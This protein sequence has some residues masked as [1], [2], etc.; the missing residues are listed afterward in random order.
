MHNTDQII[1]AFSARDKA[2]TASSEKLSKQYNRLSLARIAL[3]ICAVVAL[4]YFANA[5][6]FTAV[7]GIA[8]IFPILFGIL[9]KIHN[10]I[11]YEK[12]HALFSA[13]I[14]QQELL[15]LDRNL[16][17]FDTGERFM[18]ANHPYLADLDIFGKNSLFQLL[19]RCTTESSKQ[20]LA[21]WMSQAAPADE[22]MARQRAVQELSP[23]ID[24]RQDFQAS[25]MHYEDK[26]SNVRTLLEWLSSPTQFAGKPIYRIIVFVFPV[27]AIAA[28]VGYFWGYCHYIIPLL[29]IVLNLAIMRKATP[30]AADT[31]EKTYQSIK[32]LKSYQAMIEKIEQQ[33]FES[34]KLATLKS[35]FSHDSFSASHKIH[36]LSR[37]L[38]WLNARNNAFYFLFNIILLLDIRLLLIAEK[39]KAQAQ[40]DASKWFDAISEIEA[41]TSLA[42]FAHAHPHYTFPQLSSAPHVYQATA[43]GHP[44]LKRHARVANDFQLEGKGNIIVLTGSNMSG[45]STFLRTLGINAVLAFMGSCA[46]ASALTIGRF[47]VFT[48]MRT[49]DSL[50]ESVSSFYAE[51]RRLKQ[52]LDMVNEATPV[53]FMLDEILKGTNSHDRHKGA[54]ALIH[55]LAKQNAFGL[56]STHDLELGTLATQSDNILNYSFTSTIEKGEINFDYKLRQGICESFNATELM[57]KMG[58]EVGAID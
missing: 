45:K 30:V 26:E 25:G 40:A 44:L 29:A 24:W 33:N 50:E 13:K 42:G 41:L 56:V 27:I 37:I 55:Q 12:A 53:F 28:L 48:S 8:V 7:S 35:R 32:S 52:L 22:I 54:A 3:F 18:D 1:A 15:R 46:C 21:N 4:I 10:K 49:L 11:A 34:K 20:L 31:Q 58:I 16:K 14:N 9:L 38:D 39:W 43:I 6:D 2:F 51:L 47:Q 23:M 57:K 5:R 36:Q 19:N 17:S